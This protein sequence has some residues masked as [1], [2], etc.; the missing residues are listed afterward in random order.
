MECIARAL[1]RQSCPDM[2]PYRA[3]YSCRRLQRND[4]STRSHT[5][6]CTRTNAPFPA[7]TLSRHLTGYC[8]KWKR[9][10]GAFIANLFADYQTPLTVSTVSCCSTCSHDSRSRFTFLVT[11]I[12]SPA[13]ATCWVPLKLIENAPHTHTQ[14]HTARQTHTAV[15]RQLWKTRRKSW[16]T[17]FCCF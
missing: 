9:F 4:T 14:T 5:W 16:K 12:H 6:V 3:H 8:H 13:G 10:N 2:S 7:P 1:A 17:K 15:L 11:L